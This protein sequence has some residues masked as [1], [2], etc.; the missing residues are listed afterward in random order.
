[1]SEDNK[2]IFI[3]VRYSAFTQGGVQLGKDKTV[4]EYKK[5]LFNP[6]RLENRF[7]I[8][9][10]LTLKSLVAQKEC[11]CEVR[12]VI[13]TSIDLPKNFKELLYS[14]LKSANFK[15]NFS[16]DIVEVSEDEPLGRKMKDYVVKSLEGKG[17]NKF[18]TVRLDDDDGLSSSYCQKLCEYLD[19]DVIGFPISFAYGYEGFFDEK[20]NIFS[21]IRHWYKPKIALGL[22]FTNKYSNDNG[23]FDK[24]ITVYNLGAHTKIDLKNPIIVDSTFPAYFRTLSLYNDSG[25]NELHKLLVAVNKSTFCSDEFGFIGLIKE[26]EPSSKDFDLDKISPKDRY[27]SEIARYVGERNKYN[28]IINSKKSE[29]L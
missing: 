15:K 2:T 27:S 7:S 8:F 6:G 25:V 21:D 18:A 11:S 14:E 3:M 9:K 10:N 4:E 22:A 24:R 5:D 28:S 13:F 19:R 29:D 26:F 17:T 20:K 16:F 23:F 1:M 12:L